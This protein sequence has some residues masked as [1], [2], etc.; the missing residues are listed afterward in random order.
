M[1][2]IKANVAQFNPTVYTAG[3]QEMIPM[4]KTG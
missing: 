3:N 4:S 1:A 2:I